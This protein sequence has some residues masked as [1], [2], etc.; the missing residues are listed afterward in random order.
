M[1]KADLSLD[2]QSGQQQGEAESSVGPAPDDA[3]FL[4]GTIFF[5][6]RAGPCDRK[7]GDGGRGFD[8]PPARP[9]GSEVMHLGTGNLVMVMHFTYR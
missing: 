6:S 5:V 1:A 2:S 9:L 8:P 7:S 3:R 4:P